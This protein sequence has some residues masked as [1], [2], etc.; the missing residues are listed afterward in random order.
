MR[1]NAWALVALLLGTLATARAQSSYDPL[2]NYVIAV[3]G[4]RV[5][6]APG[7]YGKVIGAVPYGERVRVRTDEPAWRDTLGQYVDYSA[8]QTGTPIIEYWVP[9]RYQRRLGYVFGGYLA[10]QDDRCA[11]PAAE[12]LALL[13]PTMHCVENLH[14]PT[15]YHWTGV[16]RK[17]RHTYRKPVRI[18]YLYT[19]AFELSPFVTRTDDDEHL[20]FIVGSRERLPSGP[21]G[22]RWYEDVYFGYDDQLP[23]AMTDAGLALRTDAA[24]RS[25]LVCTTG[26]QPQ[27][28]PDGDAYGRLL[29][30]GDFNGDGQLDHLL[31]FGEESERRVLYLSGPNGHLYVAASW[32]GGYCC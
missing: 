5:R 9:I 1:S 20:Q 2:K 3:N 15:A 6:D 30:S 27:V 19:E 16:Y 4:L 21:L 32:R 11:P 14:A 12:T 10:Y 7:D 26:A 13:F 29:W 25:A 22:G 17:G 8:D 18:E 23:R 31:S 28:L 24:G